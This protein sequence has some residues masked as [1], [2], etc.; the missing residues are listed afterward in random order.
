MNKVI[1][2]EHHKAPTVEEIAHEIAG[3]QFFTKADAHKAFLQIH[4]TPHARLLNVFNWHKGRLQYKRMLFGAKMSQD[5]FQMWMDQ[6]LEKC[7]GVI[8]IHDNIV[9]YGKTREDHETNLVNFLNVC[10]EEGIILNGKKLELCKE[11]VTFFSALFTKEGMKPDP[12]NYKALKI[13]HLQLTSN[14]CSP[15]LA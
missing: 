11:Q 15:F 14:S 1:I 5:M 4:L 3:S 12:R 13:L 9:I 8:G 2:R 10:Q 7:P 6:I